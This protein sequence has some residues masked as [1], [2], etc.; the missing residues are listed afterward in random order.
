[1]LKH[2]VLARDRVEFFQLELFGLGARVLLGDIKESGIG[3]A[4]QLDKDGVRLGH[5][6][7]LAQGFRGPE[8][9]AGLAPVKAGS[10][11]GAVVATGAAATLGLAAMACTAWL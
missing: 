7:A 4:D 2:D 5:R 1:F 10:T 3:A 11:A 6:T 9:S 8:D